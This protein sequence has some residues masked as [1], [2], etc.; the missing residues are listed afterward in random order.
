MDVG[1]ELLG[2]P[3][4]VAVGVVDALSTLAFLDPDLGVIFELR[5]ALTGVEIPSFEAPL[6]VVSSSARGPGLVFGE[7]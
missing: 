4:G 6:G 5:K 3:F 7:T 1:R 2:V